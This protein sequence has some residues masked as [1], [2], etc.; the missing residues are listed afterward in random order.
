MRVC[1]RS[2]ADRR[3]PRAASPA[4]ATASSTSLTARGTERGPARGSCSF[5]SRTVS[6][7][8][9]GAVGIGRCVAASEAGV[10][11]AAEERLHP[12]AA[13]AVRLDCGEEPPGPIAVDDHTWVNG[14]Q[15]TSL[16]RFT[17][18][19]GLAACTPVSQAYSIALP[20]G[21]FQLNRSSGLAGSFPTSAAGRSSLS[22]G[23][24][25]YP[26]AVR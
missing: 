3:P 12:L 8:R 18:L 19:N 7:R 9:L 5:T 13:L 11:H 23:Q 16:V 6:R 4:S 15:G 22:S 20:F 26:V 2:V 21:G 14:D 17:A 25:G 24:P 10:V 1:C